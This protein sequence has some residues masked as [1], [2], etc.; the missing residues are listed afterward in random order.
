MG[1]AIQFLEHH[2]LTATALQD[3]RI[4]VRPVAALNDELRSWIRT[5]KPEILAELREPRRYWWGV[6]V[7]GNRAGKVCG[8]P[9]TRAEALD[10][11]QK[12][13]PGRVVSVF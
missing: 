6:L 11:C 1:A 8:Q 3:D 4:E 10:A 9:M 5:H 7:D 2:G 13:W 12:T